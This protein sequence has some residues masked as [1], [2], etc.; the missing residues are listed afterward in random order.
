MNVMNHDIYFSVIWFCS[1]EQDMIKI[2]LRAQERDMNH[3]D[4]V[5]FYYQILVGGEFPVH[6]WLVGLDDELTEEQLAH[7]REA[8]YPLK[9]VPI[10][11]A[12]EFSCR[13]ICYIFQEDPIKNGA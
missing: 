11:P 5:F 13:Y 3:G 6:P 12:L 4:Y 7:R 2:L 8:F 10:K 1:H 9:M